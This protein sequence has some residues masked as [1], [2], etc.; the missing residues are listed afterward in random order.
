MEKLKSI[1]KLKFIQ[2][3]PK[4]NKMAYLI[5]VGIGIG[6]SILVTVIPSFFSYGT[7]FE[8][9]IFAFA[10]FTPI[11]I[12]SII[13][14]FVLFNKLPVVWK[15]IKTRMICIVILSIV[16]MYGFCFVLLAVSGDR[17]YKVFFLPI[18]IFF[19][20]M[21]WLFTNLFQTPSSVA[22]LFLGIFIVSATCLTTKGIENLVKRIAFFFIIGFLIFISTITPLIIMCTLT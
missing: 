8:N 6:A 13:L 14:L 1:F 10:V 12:L 4:E 20:I 19:G 3:M 22:L 11:P 15:N 7:G 18:Y 16:Y 2:E 21:G 9:N 5:S 17:I